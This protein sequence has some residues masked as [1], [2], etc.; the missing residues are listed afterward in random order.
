MWN[1]NDT[2]KVGTYIRW[3]RESE[4]L[5]KIHR[6]IPPF[7]DQSIEERINSLLDMWTHSINV[8]A[9]E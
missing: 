6:F 5:N 2:P 8:L 9:G 1:G 3:N 7:F 4:L